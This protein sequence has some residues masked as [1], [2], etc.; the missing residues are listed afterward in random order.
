MKGR[1]G[2][3]AVTTAPS[4][5]GRTVY[6]NVP[7]DKYGG[8]IDQV[9]VLPDRIILNETKNVNEDFMIYASWLKTHIIA[10]FVKALPL[11][12]QIAHT[13]GIKTILLTLT[14]SVYKPATKK[15]DQMIKSLGIKIIETGKQALSKQHFK[16]WH[17]AVDT[18][19]N[20]LV[21]GTVLESKFS[22]DE[23]VRLEVFDVEKVSQCRIEVLED[24]CLVHE[25][26][27][28]EYTPNDIGGTSQESPSLEQTI[29]Y[30]NLT[31][32]WLKQ[33]CLSDIDKINLY[34]RR[35]RIQLNIQHIVSSSEITFSTTPFDSSSLSRKKSV[36][37]LYDS[38]FGCSPN[39]NTQSEMMS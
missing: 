18:F 37:N 6:Q 30:V 24:V 17:K 36:V 22:I 20:T 5:S 14:I 13:H 7:T 31:Y 16:V 11:V 12:K 21:L 29:N 25:P 39:H 4:L 1:L 10:R 26:P 38:N 9:I 23:S 28:L 15:V 35:E 27:E 2:E 3:S 8:D 32:K 19:V 34:R 33:C